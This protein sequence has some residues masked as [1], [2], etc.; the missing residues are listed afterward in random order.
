[1]TQLFDHRRGWIDV[2]LALPR[3]PTPAQQVVQARVQIANSK[4]KAEQALD[5]KRRRDD[6]HKA[7]GWR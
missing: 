6:F 3:A 4:S 5:R 1:M 2:Q 7:M